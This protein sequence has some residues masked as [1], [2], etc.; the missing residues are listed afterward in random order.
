[1]MN[2]TPEAKLVFEKFAHDY[3]LP[4]S[5]LNIAQCGSYITEDPA[6]ALN[7]LGQIDVNAFIE[8]F[9]AIKEMP[10]S[11]KDKAYSQTK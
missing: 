4:S 7:Y 6:N 8:E 11:F 1:M 10:Q 3:Q 9:N 5:F 2:M